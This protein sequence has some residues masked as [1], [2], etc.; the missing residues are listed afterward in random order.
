MIRT[1]ATSTI[2]EPTMA[3][4]LRRSPSSTLDTERTFLIGWGVPQTSPA[5][6]GVFRFIGR[7]MAVLFVTISAVLA[8]GAVTFFVVA[9]SHPVERYRDLVVGSVSWTDSSKSSDFTYQIGR[10]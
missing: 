3:S 10:A 8:A 5:P 4:M 9:H 2:P 1:V 6:S 7:L